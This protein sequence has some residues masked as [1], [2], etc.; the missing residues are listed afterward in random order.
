MIAQSIA[1]YLGVSA[2]AFKW[3]KAGKVNAMGVHVSEPT[4]ARNL[5]NLLPINMVKT[6]VN[7]TSIVLVAFLLIYLYLLLDHPAY[8]IFSITI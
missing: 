8:K 6:T 7:P 2:H 3:N 5:S 4:I 1:L